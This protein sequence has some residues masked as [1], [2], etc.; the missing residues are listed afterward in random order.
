LDFIS[1]GVNIIVSILLFILINIIVLEE[2]T[3]KILKPALLVDF[4]WTFP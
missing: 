3:N 4:L 1:I 2:N